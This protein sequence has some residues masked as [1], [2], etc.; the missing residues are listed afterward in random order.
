MVVEFWVVDCKSSSMRGLCR[1]HVGP[2]NSW[3]N[4]HAIRNCALS[5]DHLTSWRWLVFLPKG[6]ILEAILIPS[7]FFCL[8]LFRRCLGL[9]LRKPWCVC[10]FLLVSRYHFGRK[11]QLHFD[12]WR[13]CSLRFLEGIL[14][15]NTCRE[16]T[17]TATNRSSWVH[18]SE[19]FSMLIPYG[20]ELFV[21][22]TPEDV[23]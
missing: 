23:G 10:L 9:V 8:L 14:W 5:S 1:W 2:R 7:S 19:N 20:L 22:R 4:R 18:A 11:L 13:P 15:D 16:R 21:R 12:E 6:V 3:T 17:E